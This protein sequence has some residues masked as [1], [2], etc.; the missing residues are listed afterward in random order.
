ML[1]RSNPPPQARTH[2][3]LS[4]R[5][6]KARRARRRARLTMQTP[7]PVLT[8]SRSLNPPRRT[9]RSGTVEREVLFLALFVFLDQAVDELIGKLV[10]GQN[11]IEHLLPRLVGKSLPISAKKPVLGALSFLSRQR[12]FR[13]PFGYLL[14]LQWR[15][16]CTG[17]GFLATDSTY[18]GA[19][20]NKTILADISIARNCCTILRC[21]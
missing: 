16:I 7:P 20:N 17:S 4:R 3:R 8:T 14:I 21:P 6:A 5:I 10:V 19:C 2:N 12:L 11:H 13:T 15:R 18:L 9:R 1:P